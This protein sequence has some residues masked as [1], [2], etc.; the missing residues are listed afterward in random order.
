MKLEFSLLIADDNP[1]SLGQAVKA[2][3]AHLDSKGFDLTVKELDDFSSQALQDVTKQQGKN[4]DLVVIDYNLGQEQIDGTEVARQLRH[5]LPYTDMVFYS[6]NPTVDLLS[7]LAERRVSGVFVETRAELDTALV[8]L[9][10]TVIGKAVD[11]N[12]MRGIAMAQ[13]AEMDVMMEQTL[14]FVLESDNPI[15]SQVCRRTRKKLVESMRDRQ[16]SL[17]EKL[18]EGLIPVVLDN[19]LFSSHDR[20]RAIA[21]AIKALGASLGEE[22]EVLQSYREDIIDNRNLLAHAKEEVGNDN[23]SVLRSTKQGEVEVIDEDW[24]QGFRRKL[25]AHRQALEIVC[26]ALRKE[27]DSSS[28]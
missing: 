12:H 13:V 18:T 6:S 5:E 10:D 9:A 11:L 17:E 15:A 4:Y 26:E 22:S 20:Y 16:R 23:Q 24:M 21:R 27:F 14:I 7:G 8:K 28:L 19:N 2:L 1:D 25:R 3:K